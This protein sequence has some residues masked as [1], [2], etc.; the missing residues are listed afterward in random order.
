MRVCNQTAN[1]T[2]FIVTT[3]PARR[4]GQLKSVTNIGADSSSAKVKPSLTNSQTRKP[5]AAEAAV[6]EARRP[7]KPLANT[8]AGKTTAVDPYSADQAQAA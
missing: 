3:S 5:I 4:A 2:T 1:Q 7:V 8:A 6:T